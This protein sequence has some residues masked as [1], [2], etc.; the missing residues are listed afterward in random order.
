MSEAFNNSVLVPKGL[1]ADREI[2][3]ATRYLR[4]RPDKFAVQM[5]ECPIKDPNTRLN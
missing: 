5:I 4:L 2:E 3:H 1:L